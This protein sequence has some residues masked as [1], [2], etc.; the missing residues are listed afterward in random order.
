MTKRLLIYTLI[1]ALVLPLFSCGNGRR[2]EDKNTTRE[3]VVNSRNY[4]NSRSSGKGKSVIKMREEGGVYRVPCK[5][6]GTEMEFI[7]DTGASDITVS[8][9]EAKFLYKQGK[10]LDNDFVGIQQ[11]QIADGSIHEGI[12][13]ILRKVEI[14]GRLLN[15]IEASI[16]DNE[17]APL[18]LGQSALSKFGKISIDYNR[19]EIT[20]E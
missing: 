4:K 17:A 19:N 2:R 10:L 5:I 18:L 8:L 9:T 15:N 13:V 3:R 7:F 14:G 20:F 6:N 1:I 12:S 11:Y 16:V